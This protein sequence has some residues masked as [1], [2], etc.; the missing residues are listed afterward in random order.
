MVEW[1]MMPV[2]V[3]RLLVLVVY[4]SV[5]VADVQPGAAGPRLPARRQAVLSL[6]V[7]L[8]FMFMVGYVINSLQ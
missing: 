4:V 8:L 2:Y 5:S 1:A 6:L 3:Y 7:L